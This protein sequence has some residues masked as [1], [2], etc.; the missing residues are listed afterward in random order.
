MP[1][2]KRNRRMGV[3]PAMQGFKPFGI[4]FRNIQK[5]TLLFEEFESIRLADYDGLTQ[6]Q[7]AEKMNISRPTFT[8]I[9][10]KA[11]KTIAK[12]FVESIAVIISG[13]NVQLDKT[14]VKCGKCYNTFEQ[15]KL[16]IKK[17]SVCD[18][19]NIEILNQPCELSGTGKGIYYKGHK[20]TKKCI[21]PQCKKT[22]P[23][24][25]GIPCRDELC[26][27]CKINMVSGD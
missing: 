2:P 17:C 5:V 8:R 16:N 26:P 11:R 21:C 24:R 14:W 13:G 9:Y 3:P 6:E 15:D 7:A 25:P 19:E 22:I 20:A 10:D 4:P 23:H 1:R 18:S 12:A 27:E